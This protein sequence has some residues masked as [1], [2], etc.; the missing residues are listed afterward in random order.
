MLNI[1]QCCNWVN[2]KYRASAVIVNVKY[3]AS[4]VIE[5][6]LNIEQVL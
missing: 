5:L 6:M 3:R 1:E 4:A 2:V